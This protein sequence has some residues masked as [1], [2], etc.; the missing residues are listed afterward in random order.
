MRVECGGIEK[1]ERGQMEISEVDSTELGAL[2]EVGSEQ[3]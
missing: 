2:L 1:G 3:G